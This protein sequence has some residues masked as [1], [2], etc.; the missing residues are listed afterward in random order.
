MWLITLACLVI[1]V[2]LTWYS[3][4]PAGT[5]I[6]IHFVQGYGLKPGDAIEYRG[7]TI[8]HVKDVA[9][10]GDLAGIDVTAN[11]NEGS[12]AVACKGSG[13]WIVRPKIDLNGVTGLETVVGAKYISVL[14]GDPSQRQFEFTGLLA[15]PADTIGRGGIEVILRGNER[16]GVNPGSPLSWRGIDVGQVLSSSLSPD[17]RHVD[18][19]VS[20]DP[21]YRDL[22][23]QS[24]KFW[25]T[26]G[27]QM[28][29][30]VTGFDFDADSLSSVVRGGI[31]MITISGPGSEKTVQPGDVFTLHKRIDPDW[32]SSAMSINR[33]SKQSPM[34]IKIKATWKE[35]Y[36][37]IPTSK[38]DEAFALCVRDASGNHSALVPSDL[39][40]HQQSAVENT[41]S[42]V[43]SIG[44]QSVPIINSEDDAD[45]PANEE[46]SVVS[47]P[48]PKIAFEGDERPYVVVDH[49]RVQSADQLEDVFAVSYQGNALVL[50]MIGREQIA[51]V[52]QPDGGKLRWN[53]STTSLSRQLWHGAPVISADDEHV[54][55]VLLV[56][57]DVVQIVPVQTR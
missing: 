34:T 14:P 2:A 50:E 45:Q 23:R 1:A 56:S 3:M 17:A 52:R 22:V 13:F 9:L 27:V 40:T 11:L 37:G 19:R 7:M 31:S 44:D 18:T 38:S 51:A 35:R 21:R 46:P 6:V 29:L 54:I 41:Y 12:S 10:R 30:G 26:S 15:A 33:L 16:F 4:E 25:A 28:Q 20:I 8:G 55:G 5:T 57:D 49:S 39:F 42:I 48:I 36:L 43:A 32:L 24:T 47:V 53:V